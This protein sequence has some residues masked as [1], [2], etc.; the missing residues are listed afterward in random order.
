ML[1][2]Y[3]NGG[4]IM[5]FN[6]AQHIIYIVRSGDTMNSIAQKFNIPLNLLISS[7]PQILCNKYITE[8][9]ALSIVSIPHTTDAPKQ[10]DLIDVIETNAEDIIDDITK[11]DWVKAE[12][13]VKILKNSIDEL[14]PILR[15]KLVASILINNVVNAI[16]TL[17][18]EV[19]NK[20]V[21]EAKVQAN[22]I[23]G[24]VSDLLD[25]FKPAMPTDLVRLDF[26]GR[27]LTFNAEKNDWRYA[28]A[29]LERADEI[30]ENLKT[31]LSSEFSKD[32]TEFNQI[33]DSLEQSI[34]KKDS[35]QTIKNAN[36]M[37]DKVD[38]LEED[39]KKQS[40]NKNLL[41]A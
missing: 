30:W 19:A 20:N 16:A 14:K 17:E 23:T 10:I 2:K 35:A 5:Q 7:N 8:G 28:N 11:K 31:K 37:L 9:E 33:L 39:F 34:Q 4:F 13:K 38:A 15:A 40:E 27:E 21:Y 12:A 41:Q 26:L 22:F 36:D 24:N 25:Y 6:N 32:I 18:K 1:I 29:N 3:K